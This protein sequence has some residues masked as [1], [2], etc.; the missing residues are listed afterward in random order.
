MSIIKEEEF[1]Y[2]AYTRE[3]PPDPSKIHRGPQ[4]SRQR[5]ERKIKSMV[6]IDADILEQFQALSS[7]EYQC[8]NL[9]NRALRDWLYAK[10]MKELV[11]DELREIIQ[12]VVSSSS[13]LAQQSKCGFP[14]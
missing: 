10:T 3:H 14:K 9:I 1:D 4:A 2:Q 12:Q 5:L 6:H 7:E 13:Q 8:E 11:R